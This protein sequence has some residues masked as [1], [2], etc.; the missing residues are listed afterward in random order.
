MREWTHRRQMAIAAHNAARRGHVASDCWARRRRRTHSNSTA[1]PA[2]DARP[3]T[4]IAGR[5]DNHGTVDVLRGVVHQHRP[6]REQGGKQRVVAAGKRQRGHFVDDD[7]ASQSAGI[8]GIAPMVTT[9]ATVRITRRDRHTRWLG[10]PVSGS[11][12][13]ASTGKQAKR[14][15]LPVPHEAISAPQAQGSTREHQHGAGHVWSAPE[16]QR[17]VGSGAGA[18]P[19][20]R[21]PTGQSVATA[22]LPRHA[23]HV[24]RPLSV[25]PTAATG[26]APCPANRGQT[27]GSLSTAQPAP[28][29]TLP[30]RSHALRQGSSSSSAR[31]PR[32]RPA[33]FRH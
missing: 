11:A 20:D 16:R 30:R 13:C 21:V 2:I 1:P 29:S 33:W 9:F 7:A 8:F 15:V 19:A 10:V 4:V 32:A 5:G 31:Q 17:G 23:A 12:C 25:W 3:V 24:G 28:I 18:G 14:A 6:G 27:P 26:T 22:T